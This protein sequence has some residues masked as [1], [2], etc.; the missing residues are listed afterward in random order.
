MTDIRRLAL[1]DFRADGVGETVSVNNRRGHDWA[2]S[3]PLVVKANRRSRI[4][5]EYLKFLLEFC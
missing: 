5:L 1:M 4:L 3:G 2:P